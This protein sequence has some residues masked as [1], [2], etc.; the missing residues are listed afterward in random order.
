MKRRLDFKGQ[1][2]LAVQIQVGKGQIKVKTGRQALKKTTKFTGGAAICHI[3]H[4]LLV[5]HTIFLNRFRIRAIAALAAYI[6]SS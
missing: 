6:Y 2:E 5:L 4:R 1:V 3:R